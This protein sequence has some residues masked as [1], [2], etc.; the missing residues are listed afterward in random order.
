MGQ[1]LPFF[2]EQAS[3]VAGRVDALFLF[4][5][6]V[7]ALFA[8]LIFGLIA[9]FA[10]KYRARPGNERA[11]RTVTHMG[12]EITWTAIPLLLT[13]VMFAWGAKLFFEVY[14]PPPGAMQVFVV[15][16]QWMWKFQHPEGQREIDEL[17]V[18]VG[19]PIQL[20]MISE[21]VI[22]DLFVPAFRVKMDVLP[23]RYTTMWFQATRVGDLSSVLL[24]VLRH[25][26]REDGG[27]GVC[28][29]AGGLPEMAERR[30]GGRA[31]GSE[32]R[33]IVQSIGVYDMPSSQQYGARPVVGGVVWQTCEIADGR[34][35]P[36]G[37]SVH[38]GI[39][40]QT[41][42]KNHGRVPTDHADI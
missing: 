18:P 39:D 6:G 32:R 26:T 25:R 2:P 3:T 29:V 5:I 41:E 13:S 16:K 31:T 28:V 42:R 34:D 17:H 10:V 7:S 11:Q 19:R 12:L 35:R 33:A 36:G 40:H 8:L 27:M 15:G 30:P 14:R 38:P 23:G 37:R 9:Y 22:H 4:L 21:D 24:A 1:G 20:T